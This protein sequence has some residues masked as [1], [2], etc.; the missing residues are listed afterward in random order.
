MSQEIE[1]HVVSYEMAKELD[2][3]YPTEFCWV[4]PSNADWYVRRCFGANLLIE[5]SVPA[6]MLTE[7]ME[8]LFM[9]DKP[10]DVLAKGI[11]KILK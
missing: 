9:V 8:I 4:K 11:F 7:M 10:C 6:P 5:N 3:P 1:K 2:W